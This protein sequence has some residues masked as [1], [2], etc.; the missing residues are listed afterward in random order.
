MDGAQARE[1]DTEPVESRL[2]PRRGIGHGRPD[3]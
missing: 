2:R 1:H 3:M